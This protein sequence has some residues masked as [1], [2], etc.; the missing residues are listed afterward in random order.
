MKQFFVKLRIAL[1]ALSP[2]LIVC[3]GSGMSRLEAA[4]LVG[5]AT[6]NR[7]LSFDSANPG[8]IL[9]DTAVSGLAPGHALV[10]IDYRPA[11]QQL[12]G[13]GRDPGSG[14]AQ[15][16]SLNTMTG[17]ATP[18][19]SLFTLAGSAF[20][21]D[22]NPVPNALRLVTDA[23]G[24]LRITGGGTGTVNTDGSLSRNPPN[25]DP[26]LRVNA[27]AYS[28]NFA[29]GLNGVTTLYVIDAATG[30]LYTQ[31]S[32][33]FP[34]GTSPNTGNL[35]LVGS[36]GLGANLSDHIGFDIRNTGEAFVSVVT[37]NGN[38]LYSID[39]ASGQTSALGAIGTGATLLD[40]TASP[41]PEP[42]TV[43]LTSAALVA[44]G[45]LKRTR[46]RR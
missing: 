12:I 4:P 35:F 22:F 29:G 2:V 6:G 34:P 1:V 9:M 39:V 18:I 38:M 10:G 5:L 3:G 41:V 20:G 32:L 31:G 46:R 19:S 37:G 42:S 16:Y 24:N 27:A 45:F 11:D 7:L 36:L 17:A 26:A 25:A 40:I 33:N 13:L 43:L 14:Q 15:V 28:N 23:E 44:V 8:V 21:I 30:N